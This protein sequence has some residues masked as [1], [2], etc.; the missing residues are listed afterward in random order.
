METAAATA[1]Y[2]WADRPPV[3]EAARALGINDRR[4]AKLIGI[5]PE[6][7]HS[8]VSGRR[9]IPHVHTLAL[10]FIVGRLT[11]AIS[12]SRPVKSRYCRR[13]ELA[14]D[15]ANRWL[16]LAKLELAEDSG[17]DDLSQHPEVMRAYAVGEAA[18]AK[19]EQ[20]DAA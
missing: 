12:P 5:L 17:F 4:V 18:L 7:V 16:E 8:W 10:I 6:Q 14:F 15:C 9:P 11:G 1:A 20:A 19:L 2:R 3:L 13:A